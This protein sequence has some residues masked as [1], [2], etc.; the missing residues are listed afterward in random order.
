MPRGSSGSGSASRA[1]PWQR[2]QARIRL[3]PANISMSW[4]EKWWAE[5]SMRRARV[6]A[7]RGKALHARVEVQLRALP[8]LRFVDQ[9]VEKHPAPAAERPAS[10]VTRSST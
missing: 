7:V 9:P 2:G 4:S 5:I 3:V 8:P 6:E 1:S 10:A